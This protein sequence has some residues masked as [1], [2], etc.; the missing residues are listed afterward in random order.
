MKR[1]VLFILIGALLCFIAGPTPTDAADTYCPPVQVPPGGVCDC[2]VFNY[3]PEADTG[4]VIEMYDAT[5][6]THEVTNDIASG[7]SLYTS[8]P[9]PVH[10]SNATTVACRV[11][12]IGAHARVTLQCYMASSLEVD[13]TVYVT[14]YAFA[15]CSE[16]QF[17]PPGQKK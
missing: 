9:I 8:W 5:G 14:T 17:T 2:A 10:V 7:H 4:V 13:P 12:G 16:S 15:V 3:G 1:Q 11:T 6:V